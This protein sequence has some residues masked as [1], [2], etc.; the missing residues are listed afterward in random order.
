MPTSNQQ[1]KQQG[2][3]RSSYL[4]SRSLIIM[5]RSLSLSFPSFLCSPALQ[6]G[7]RER[8]SSYPHPQPSPA[9][10]DPARFCS[11]LEPFLL[12][13]PVPFLSFPF[14]CYPFLSCPFLSFPVLSFPIL[15]LSYPFFSFHLSLFFITAEPIS[16]KEKK[17]GGK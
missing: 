5:T 17:G 1:S 8:T 6:T 7:P 2:R 12:S 11:I 3:V 9:Q 16:N 14:L 15:F 4:P 10:L 13:F